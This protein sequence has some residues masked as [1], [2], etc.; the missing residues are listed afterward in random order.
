MIL[1]LSPVPTAKD[2]EVVKNIKST[3]GKVKM[4][5]F[6][7]TKLWFDATESS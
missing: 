1:L 2:L 7:A 3:D 4:E 6:V 5:D